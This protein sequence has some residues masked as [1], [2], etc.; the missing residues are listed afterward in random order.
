MV[1]AL[2][3]SVYVILN[4]VT[5]VAQIPLLLG[6]AASAILASTRRIVDDAVCQVMPFG[7]VAVHVSHDSVHLS[8]PHGILNVYAHTSGFCCSICSCI[9][10]DLCLNGDVVFENLGTT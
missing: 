3:D 8:A 7:R 9:R 4:R 10:V 6:H 5:S 2:P 1:L